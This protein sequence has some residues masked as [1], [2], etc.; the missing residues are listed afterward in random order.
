MRLFAIS[1]KAR[2]A[3]LSSLLIGGHAVIAHGHPRNTFDLD[4]VIPRS[5]VGDWRALLLGQ[6]YRIR[7]EGTTF[8]QFDPPD[9]G[10]LPLD[11]MLVSP[12]TFSQFEAES[13][14]VLAEDPAGPRMVALRHLL[15][16]KSHAIR[17]GH[18]G[19]VEKD[20]DDVIGLMQANRLDV[21]ETGW[22]EL[23]LKHGPPELH[24]KLLQIQRR[25]GGR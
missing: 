25:S 5:A 17:H 16:L 22:R 14:P 8:V 1:Q 18:P 12:E 11:L 6:G 15:A 9:E 24:A 10:T 13:V 7:L 2:D 21:N 23:F 4:L 3:G 19:R 20:V